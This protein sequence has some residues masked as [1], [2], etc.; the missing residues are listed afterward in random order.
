MTQPR[1]RW[2]SYLDISA[3]VGML[4]VSLGLAW[5]NFVRPALNRPSVLAVPKQ[6]IALPGAP[7]AG[8][9]NSGVVLMEFADFQCPFCAKFSVEIL[10]SIQQK[11]VQSGKIGLVF[12]NFPLRTLHPLASRAASIAVCAAEEGGFWQLHDKLFSL[13]SLT[14]A[15]LDEAELRLRDRSC[16]GKM[17]SQKVRA[18]EILGESLGVRSTPTFFFARVLADGSLKFQAAL[19]GAQPLSTFE[20]VLDRLAATNRPATQ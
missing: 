20:K 16:P 4:L 13:S 11:Y 14:S 2:K 9:I 3:S 10:P 17:G 18:D 1:G 6:T 19:E 5:T 12:L 7:I 8:Q 15:S